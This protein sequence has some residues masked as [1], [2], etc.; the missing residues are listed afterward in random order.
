MEIKGLDKFISNMKTIKEY[1][2]N[3]ASRQIYKSLKTIEKKANEYAPKDTG[4]LQESSFTSSLNEV[5]RT[6][7]GM[8]GYDSE[9]AIPVHEGTKPHTV[10]Y[11]AIY[12]WTLRKITTDTKEAKSIAWAI[13]KSIEKNGTSMYSLR[14]NGDKGYKFLEKAMLE[15][16]PNLKQSFIT[17]FKRDILEMKI[18]R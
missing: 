16:L 1:L 4:K 5:I 14:N 6:K 17:D 15:V 3:S 13:V 9:Y 18:K 8:V 12:Q 2:P 10:P 11:E 7:E